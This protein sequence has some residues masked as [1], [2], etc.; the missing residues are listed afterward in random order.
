M[1]K[2]LGF[3]TLSYSPMQI[4]KI[5]IHSQMK[6]RVNKNSATYAV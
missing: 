5:I 2:V 1:K 4:C 3:I 6:V